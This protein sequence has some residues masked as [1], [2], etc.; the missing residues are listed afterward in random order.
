MRI[1]NIVSSN[2]V[3]DPRILKQMETI[4]KLTDDYI[5]LGKNNAN[6][7]DERLKKIDFNYKLFGLNKSENTIFKKLINRVKF[8][9]NVIRFIKEFEPDVIHANDFDVLFIVFLSKR[10]NANIVYDAH[11]IYSKNAFINKYKIISSIVQ[12]I[13]KRIIKNIHAFITVSHAAKG[14]YNSSNYPKEAIVVTNAPIKIENSSYVEKKSDVFE[15]VYQGQIVAN[16]GYE[17]FLEAGKLIENNDINLII[18]GFGHLTDHLI[19]LKS[20]N[21]LENVKIEK[22]VEV[23]KLISAL[24]RSHVGVVLTKGTSINF[25]YTVSNKIFECIH[26]GLPVILSPVKEHIYLN[27]KYNFGIILDEVTSEKIADAILKL[28]KNPELYNEL[29]ENAIKASEELTWQNESKKLID[30]YQEALK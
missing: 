13:E 29:K 3:Q 22:P 12:I 9:K 16:R 15:V 30:L 5:V 20:K 14:Y 17:E 27:E 28:K 1:L 10:K 6:V 8:G 2:I 4:K 25:E 26:A 18:R 24:T 7:T 21:G 11:E 23:S 19:D